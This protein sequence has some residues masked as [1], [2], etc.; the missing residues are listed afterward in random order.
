MDSFLKY[1]WLDIV[2]KIAT[3]LVYNQ[4][5]HQTFSIQGGRT[6]EMDYVLKAY[7]GV[8]LPS[9]KPSNVLFYHNQHGVHNLGKSLSICRIVLGGESPGIGNQWIDMYCKDN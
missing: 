9:F 1:A 4:H 8:I 3:N 2:S 5:T 6:G 7:M